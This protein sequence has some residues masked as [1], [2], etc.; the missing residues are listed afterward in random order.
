MPLHRRIIAC[1]EP[2]H[3]KVYA[4]YVTLAFRV[5]M[6]FKFN[7]APHRFSLTGLH[8][9]EVGDILLVRAVE[10]GRPR[11]E[12]FTNRLNE[13]GTPLH[14]TLSVRDVAPFEAVKRLRSERVEPIEEP[15]DWTTNP[16]MTGTRLVTPFLHANH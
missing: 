2:Q 11:E 3:P 7:R 14:L 15:F 10:E 5:P 8:R 4:M 16:I 1:F 9:D 12:A 13:A 6:N